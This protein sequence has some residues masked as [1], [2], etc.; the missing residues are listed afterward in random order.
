M[1]NISTPV[2]LTA[3]L[4]G[5]GG[6][7]TITPLLLTANFVTGFVTCCASGT[8]TGEQFAPLLHAKYIALSDVLTHPLP[9]SYVCGPMPRMPFAPMSPVV[10]SSLPD[11]QPLSPVGAADAFRWPMIWIG[12]LDATSVPIFTS[13]V[14]TVPHV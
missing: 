9:Q 11:G 1:P 6:N 10:F 2:A 8:A 7:C 5:T 14:R 3:P 13:A 4:S 12:T